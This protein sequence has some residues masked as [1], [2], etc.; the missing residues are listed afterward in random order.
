MRH[1]RD[2]CL[3]CVDGSLGVGVKHAVDL[4][5]LGVEDT[6]AICDAGI[7]HCMR[8]T[9]VFKSPSCQCQS[10]FLRLFLT[11]NVDVINR[12]GL[13]RLVHEELRPV[14]GADRG[15][16]GRGLDAIVLPDGLG[17]RLGAA[18]GRV[19]DVVEGDVG[20]VAR[21][22]DGDAGADAVLAA[23]AGYDGDLA[24]EGEGVGGHS[25]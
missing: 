8:H 23:G 5:R 9:L 24:L 11:E 19:A 2:D 18:G 6:T 3:D 25:E 12:E 13:E 4:V 20:A 14:L 16:D 22:G 15:L 21:Q 1:V 7:V 10:N 17:E